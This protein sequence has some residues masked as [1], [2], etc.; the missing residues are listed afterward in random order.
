MGAYFSNMQNENRKQYVFDT[1]ACVFISSTQEVKA[2][3]L[4]WVWGQP[5]KSSQFEVSKPD[6]PYNMYAGE[7]LRL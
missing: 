2:G 3:G 6:S 7:L 5:G 1:V 4:L